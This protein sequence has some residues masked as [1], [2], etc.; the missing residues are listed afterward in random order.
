MTTTLNTVLVAGGQDLQDD[1]G[2]T[3]FSIRWND[4][5]RTYSV[6]G[7]VDM[8]GSE[9]FEWESLEAAQFFALAFYAEHLHKN[10]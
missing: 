10:A 8:N 5:D 7:F 1:D 4:E 6:D 9:L 3:L 2:K